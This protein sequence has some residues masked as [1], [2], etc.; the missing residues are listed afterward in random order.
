[1]EVYDISSEFDS[2]LANISTRG[3]VGTGD[4]VLISGFIVGDV[5]HSTVVVR[6]LGPSLTS[7]GI[8]EAVPDP[9]LTVYDS[10]GSAIATND[11]WRDD[12]TALDIMQNGLAPLKAAEAATILHLQAGSYTAIAT[13]A[14][15][16]SGTGLIEVYNLQ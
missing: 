3:T 16:S 8:R 1:M 10:N 7:A 5:A 13:G 12:P 6:A 11:N 14:D 9:A 15:E 4:A 2:S